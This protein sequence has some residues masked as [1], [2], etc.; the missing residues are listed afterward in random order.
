M[1]FFSCE[2]VEE[3]DTTQKRL[4]STKTSIKAYNANVIWV[5]EYK[6]IENKWIEIEIWTYGHLNIVVMVTGLSVSADQRSLATDIFNYWLHYLFCT[7]S[8]FVYLDCFNVKEACFAWSKNNE[9]QVRCWFL[10]DLSPTPSSLAGRSWGN[11]LHR[12]RALS[13]AWMHFSQCVARNKGTLLKL[14]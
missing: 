11:W 6:R 13:Q 10:S 2:A 3:L 5:Y 7:D 9:R 1:F 14:S 12:A 8:V 4:D